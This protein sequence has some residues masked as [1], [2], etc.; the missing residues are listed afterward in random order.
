MM[1]LYS[2]I[3]TDNATSKW[4]GPDACNNEGT[5]SLLSSKAA[6]N[7]DMKYCKHV[8]GRTPASRNHS[9]MASSACRVMEKSLSIFFLGGIRQ[10]SL[11][12]ARQ[13]SVLLLHVPAQSTHHV[14]KQT[15]QKGK[16]KEITYQWGTKGCPD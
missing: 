3:A 7:Q 4:L 16:R 6:R 11:S 2:P 5:G 1:R 15:G 9:Q 12:H 14:Q 8:E 13:Q 10:M